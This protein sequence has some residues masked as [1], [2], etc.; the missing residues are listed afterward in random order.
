MQKYFGVQILLKRNLKPKLS[1]KS[2]G[3]RFQLD[4]Y[5]QISPVNLHDRTD[6]C[7]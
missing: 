7:S 3:F 6:L 1:A 5:A 4:T 2:L